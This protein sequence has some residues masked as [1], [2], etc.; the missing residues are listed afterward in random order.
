MATVKL[1]LDSNKIYHKEFEGTKPGYDSL[2]VDSFLDI[3]IKDYDAFAQYQIDVQREMDELH[4]KIQ[5]LTDQISKVEAEN[6]Q[7]QNKLSGISDN[8]EASLN[9]LEYIKRVASLEKALKK[10]G[11]NPNTID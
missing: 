11:I 5:I 9:N 10:A 8:S 6:V 4:S 1:L 7:L 2:Q 3:V